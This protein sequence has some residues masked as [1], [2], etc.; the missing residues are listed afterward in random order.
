MVVVDGEKIGLLLIFSH[1]KPQV[2][3]G[4][5]SDMTEYAFRIKPHFSARTFNKVSTILYH[6]K[7]N[8]KSYNFCL[9]HFFVNCQPGKFCGKK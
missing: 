1:L 2:M 6:F 8:K 9:E 4:L 5:G 7:G 3:T